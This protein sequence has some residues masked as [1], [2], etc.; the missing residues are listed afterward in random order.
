MQLRVLHLV[1][2]STGASWAFRQTRELVK[3]G[4]EVHVALPPNGNSSILENSGM[5]VHRLQPDLPINQPWI[6]PRRLKQLRALISYVNPHVIHSHFVGTTLAMR[7]SLGKTHWTPR[8]FQVPGPLHLEHKF[9]RELDVSTAGPVDRW[10]ASC[11]WTYDRYL[12]EGIRKDRVFLSYYGI[13][14]NSFSNAYP[15]KLRCELGLASQS[16]LIG[17][18]AYMY[19]P[20]HYLGQK[21]GIKGHEDLIDAVALCRQR[22]PGIKVVFIGGAWNNATGYERTIH[23]YARQRLGN[24]A[25]FLGTRNDVNQLYPD[26]DVAVHPSHSENL[27]GAGES[28]LSCIP[29]IATNLGGFPDIVIPNQ[30][31]WLV[32][33]HDPV[34]L[35]D[36]IIEVLRDP[37]RARR[38]A[39]AGRERV[40]HLLDIRENARQ[41]KEIY[42]SVL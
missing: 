1:K 15:G 34:R 42:D 2:T 26:L 23:R 22:L 21:R 19:P 4:I 30:T 7:L 5:T 25:I 33:A 16:P 12:N 8:L 29:T 39:E 36:T 9:F 11:Q 41:I 32:P 18:V 17:M 40:R 35:A 24:G 14:L 6:W 38:L 20:K 3:L 10:V 37:L 28:L 13:D 27:G 31:G